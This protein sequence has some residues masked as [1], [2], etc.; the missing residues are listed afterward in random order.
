MEEARE[1]VLASCKPNQN[2]RPY[3]SVRCAHHTI[4]IGALT[5]VLGRLA[6]VSGSFNWEFCNLDEATVQCSLLGFNRHLF[7]LNHRPAPLAP[8]KKRS[9]Y[10]S[11]RGLSETGFCQI[12]LATDQAA[13][14]GSV[15]TS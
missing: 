12:C 1:N 13:N 10:H 9:D 11:R 15:A 3:F 14:Q 5:T 7:F 6:C 8:F 4:S 2:S